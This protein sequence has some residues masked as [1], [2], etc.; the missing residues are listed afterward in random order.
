MLIDLWR[1]D[2][3]VTY[4]AIRVWWP[5]GAVGVVIVALHEDLVPTTDQ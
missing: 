5:S 2:L 1:D 4:R 3:L